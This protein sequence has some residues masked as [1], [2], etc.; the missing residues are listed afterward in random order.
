MAEFHRSVLLEE[1]C[2][3]LEP[4]LARPPR[5]EGGEGGAPIRYVDLTTGGAGHAHA[6]ASRFAPDEMWLFDRDLE[7][8]A[9][10]KVRLADTAP[11]LH[12]IHAPFS[13]A[14]T[15]LEAAGIRE[16]QG[17][18]ADLGVS[19]HQLDAGRRGFSF[20]ADAPLDMRMDPSR[21][22]SAA[23]L[24]A[25]SSAE[26]L[27]RLLRNYGEEAD[28]GRIARAIVDSGPKT[29]GEL[30][31][32]VRDAMSARQRRKLGL[33]IDPATKTFQALRIA[34]NDE[35]GELE[36][37]LQ[38]GPSLL[39]PGGR[40]ALISFHSLE[41]RRIKQCFRKL[42]RAPEPPPGLPVRAED[43]AKPD[44]VSPRQFAKGSTAGPE[45][46]E[47]NPRARSARLRVLERQTQP[48]S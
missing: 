32:I 48:T 23:E 7:A 36:R 15:H 47:A 38:D 46:L 28:A 9:E 3:A 4:A 12:F 26:Q 27:A 42:S 25:D 45:E 19:S 33:R 10:A 1:V 24:I 5:G 20:R 14:A 8:L 18:L 39:A 29:T 13:E 44:F 22:Q 37:L 40:L 31:Q 2:Q 35:L 34:V 43:I 11:T 6:V 16:V 21:G 17:I 30:A 41:D